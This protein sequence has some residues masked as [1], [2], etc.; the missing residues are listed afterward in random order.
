MGLLLYCQPAQL[1]VPRKHLIQSHIFSLLYF[2]SS[3]AE[4][5]SVEITFCVFKA[6]IPRSSGPMNED[7]IYPCAR[8]TTKKKLNG[9]FFQEVDLQLDI[10]EGMALLIGAAEKNQLSESTDSAARSC[11]AGSIDR[12]G[13]QTLTLIPRP[14]SRLSREELIVQTRRRR[15]RQI[16]NI[17]ARIRASTAGLRR[18]LDRSELRITT[19]LTM[20]MLTTSLSSRG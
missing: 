12:G 11:G 15:L 6:R 5:V 7:I 18:V 10:I 17:P 16:V 20:T 2:L 8:T 3:L 14:S 19:E 1:P 4:E 13:G 9:L